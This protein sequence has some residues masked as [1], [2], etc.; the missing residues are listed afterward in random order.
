MAKRNF[1]NVSVETTL[2]TGIDSV[3][4]TLTVDD[5]TGY[6]A[7]P[8]VI[9]L[10]VDLVSEEIILVGSRTG[11]SFSSLTRGFGGTI[12]STHSAGAPIEHV[13][14]AEDYRLIF[15]HIHRPGTDDTEAIN[16][17]NLTNIGVNQHHNRDHSGRHQ[18]GGADIITVTDDMV[19]FGIDGRKLLDNSVRSAELTGDAIAPFIVTGNGNDN[20][21]TD[22]TGSF[23]DFAN[24]TFNKP[25]SWG[26]YT[27]LVMGSINCSNEGI[28]GTKE[29]QARARVGINNGIAL[30]STS[31][32]DAEHTIGVSAKFTGLVGASNVIALQA[33]ELQG[34]MSQQAST[35][36]GIFL[37][38]T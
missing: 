6:P 27:A 4:T 29:I 28:S 1:T 24:F 35:I 8:F 32:P 16:H 11:T 7:A 5:D 21:F 38:T 20:T 3:A 10:D 14:V 13:A 18:S 37:R 15:N 22:L 34:H 36:I 19:A 12:A 30:S 26:E 2:T 31:D 17:G 25:S 23:Q 33:R 9:R